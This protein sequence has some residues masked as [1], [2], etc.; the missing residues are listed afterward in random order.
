MVCDRI[1]KIGADIGKHIDSFLFDRL[2]FYLAKFEAEGLDN[3]LF[4][5]FPHAVPKQ[6]GL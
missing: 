3:M 1:R 2:A 6:A 5:R 4:L